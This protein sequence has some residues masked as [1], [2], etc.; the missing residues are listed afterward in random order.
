[1]AAERDRGG[2]GTGS[3]LAQAHCGGLGGLLHGPL[4]GRE[5][6]RAGEIIERKSGR[7]S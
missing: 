4:V 3:R 7:G 1:V 5:N 2:D 6:S